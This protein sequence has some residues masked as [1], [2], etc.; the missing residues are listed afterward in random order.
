[1]QKTALVILINKWNDM[2]WY[3]MIW[4]ALIYE[5]KTYLYIIE[6]CKL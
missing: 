1:M 2:K 4:N 6:Y 3:E 5:Q